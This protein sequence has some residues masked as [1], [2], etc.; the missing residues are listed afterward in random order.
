MKPAYCEIES[1]LKLSARIGRDRLLTQASNGN[2][3]I[4]LDRTLWIKASGK[5]LSNA[6]KEDILVPVDLDTAKDC[7]WRNKDFKS[8]W[9]DVS[10]RDLKPSIETGMHAVLGHR[11]VIHVHSV[12]SIAVAIRS[13]ARQ[14]LRRRLEG[15]H[16]EWVPYVASGLPL[17]AAV[18]RVVRNSPRT[19]VI[20]LGNHG[21]IVCGKDCDTVEEL[22]DEVEVRLALHPRHAPEFDDEFLRRLAQGSG[23]RLPEHT[24][25]HSLATDAISGEIFSRG[26]LYPCQAI[27]LGAVEQYKYFYA[28]HDSE[29]AKV[30]KCR[31]GEAFV[32]VKEKGVLISD[33]IASAEY[34]TVL[35]LVQVLQRVDDPSAIRYLTS[36]ELKAVSRL[37]AY[38]TTSVGFETPALSA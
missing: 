3:S 37:A 28:E 23:W 32:L 1:L 8:V 6:L 24:A 20:V 4:K 29:A 5:W 27:F 18:E 10:G 38:R 14:Q 12:N 31:R 34:E 2:T 22:L 7:V 30:L 16:W 11:V 26:V 21:L 35:G 17:A 19:D 33:N 15:L 25:L 13:D 36:G 9:I